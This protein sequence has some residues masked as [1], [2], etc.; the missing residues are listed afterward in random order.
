M[1]SYSIGSLIASTEEI[2]LL[3]NNFSS[4]NALEIIDGNLK[5]TDPQVCHFVSFMPLN[6]N[7]IEF[8]GLKTHPVN[9]GPISKDMSWIY[10]A[11]KAIKKYIQCF[12]SNENSFCLLSLSE[13]RLTS[14]RSQLE[15]FQ[16]T[17]MSRVMLESAIQS[18]E[19]RKS[20]S[21]RMNEFRRMNYFPLVSEI[22][23]EFAREQELVK[24]I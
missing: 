4:P 8:D 12:P 15:S 13:N 6:G 9:H 23:K 3:H 17:Q 21:K 22:I 7:L 20:K 19:Q 10:G 1:D 24:R 11:E 14:L 2:K 5:K 18:E 16:G